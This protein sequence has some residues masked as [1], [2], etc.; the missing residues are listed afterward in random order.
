MIAAP[1]ATLL[2]TFLDIVAPWRDVF[3]QG[4]TYRRAV[5]QA[6]GSLLCLGRRCLSR[7]IWTNGGQHRS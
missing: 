5:R 7:I 3:P 4:R 1:T 2:G 6:V